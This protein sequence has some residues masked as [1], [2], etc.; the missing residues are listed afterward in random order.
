M[1]AMKASL[2]LTREQ[3]AEIVDTFN[4]VVQDDASLGLQPQVPE[5]L[6]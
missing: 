5:N 6:R 3:I 4:T 1:K 2:W